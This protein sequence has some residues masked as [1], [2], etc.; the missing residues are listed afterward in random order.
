MPRHRAEEKG[1]IWREYFWENAIGDSLASRIVSN[2]LF[3]GAN[4]SRRKYSL[5]STTPFAE[6]SKIFIVEKF[7]KRRYRLFLGAVESVITK[8]WDNWSGASVLGSRG[9]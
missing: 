8:I 4:T 2:G 7:P 1:G 5:V 3:F 9:L 6:W